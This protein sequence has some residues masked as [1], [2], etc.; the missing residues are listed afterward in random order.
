MRS[1]TSFEVCSSRVRGVA[2]WLALIASALR[3]QWIETETDELRTACGVSWDLF[4]CAT[5]LSC[6]G[7]ESRF[8]WI[9]LVML[10]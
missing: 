10:D 4:W 5:F 9:V 1:R 7:G 2:L 8:L 6:F 3:P